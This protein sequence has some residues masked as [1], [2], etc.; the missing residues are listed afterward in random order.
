MARP[1]P[2]LAPVTRATLLARS[3]LFVIAGCYVGVPR[4]HSRRGAPRRERFPLRTCDA[5]P[6]LEELRQPLAE[7][8]PRAQ[9]VLDPHVDRRLDVQ[10][11]VLAAPQPTD[12]PGALRGL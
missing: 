7:R 3:F 4:P 9:V 5:P 10:A 2:R 11:R 12:V 6:L 1:M 8:G